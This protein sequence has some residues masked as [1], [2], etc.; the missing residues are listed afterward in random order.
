MYDLIIKNGTVIDGT[1][2]EGFLADVAVKDG[3]I[4]AVGQVQG[5]AARVI[6]AAGLTVTPGFI[7]SHSHSDNSILT[8]PD[9]TEKIEQGITT[10]IGGQCGSSPAPFG[11]DERDRDLGSYGKAS[12]VRKTMGTFL[13][14]AKNLSL[15]SNLAVFVGHKSLRRAVI[16][17]YDR[18]PTAQELE[19]MA[20][21][22]RE[23]IQNGAWGLSFG[24]IYPPAA[25]PRLTS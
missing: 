19:Q 15:G 12:I 18:A 5:E 2:A 21:L 11:K 4:V 25:T 3:K 14:T 20:D 24:L 23:G 8:F 10:S 9:Q 1:G 6:D 16:G 13:N 7:D 17:P 22:L